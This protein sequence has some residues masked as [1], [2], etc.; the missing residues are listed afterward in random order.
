METPD[1]KKYG[2]ETKNAGMETPKEPKSRK[3]KSRRPIKIEPKAK[4]CLMRE[5][6][7]VS[8]VSYSPFSSPDKKT[9]KLAKS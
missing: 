2:D 4:R 5:F 8:E 6:N 7:R 3:R 9:N 1:S